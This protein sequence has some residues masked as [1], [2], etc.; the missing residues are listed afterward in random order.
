MFVSLLLDDG[1]QSL[2]SSIRDLHEKTFSRT[3]FDPSKDPVALLQ[4]SNIGLSM[5]KLR[6]VDF[7]D[8][9]A[10]II[11]E[12][13]DGLGIS[14]QVLL[15]NSS[16]EICPVHR[17]MSRTN[18][19]ADFVLNL[20]LEHLRC[21]EIDEL[22]HLSQRQMALSEEGAVTDRLEVLAR[23]ASPRISITQTSADDE[24]HVHLE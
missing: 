20:F 17:G 2:G 5:E 7:D 8:N 6:L 13:S 24:G 21:P 22:H 3:P 15:T 18:T 19:N 14:S 12:T 1:Q 16:A 23:L 10:A 11:V 4:P 9:R